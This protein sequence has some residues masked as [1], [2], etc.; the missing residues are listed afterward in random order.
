MPKYK[1]DKGVFKFKHDVGGD[2]IPG[3]DNGF[4]FP[5]VVKKLERPGHD[6]KYIISF[7]LWGLELYSK[8][9]KKEEYKHY[10]KAAYKLAQ[11]CAYQI[12]FILKFTNEIMKMICFT[13]PIKPDS[14]K[15]VFLKLSYWWFQ[16]DTAV[17]SL[18]APDGTSNLL[19]A[20][21]KLKYYGDSSD[22]NYI[23]DKTMLEG[24]FYDSDRLNKVAAWLSPENTN[25]MA[26]DNTSSQTES[27][28]EAQCCNNIN[29]T[30]NPKENLSWFQWYIEQGREA[31]VTVAALTGVAIVGTLYA[32]KKTYDYFWSA[33]TDSSDSESSDNFD[34]SNDSNDSDS[35]P[36]SPSDTDSSSESLPLAELPDFGMP[37]E[38]YY[39][40]D[41]SGSTLPDS[42]SPDDSAATAHSRDH[43]S[44]SPHFFANRTTA[45]TF[46][47]QRT[48]GDYYYAAL[49]VAREG[50]DAR[51]QIAAQSPARKY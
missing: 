48:F 39:S 41:D 19:A 28:H 37:P 38:N 1:T 47:R 24:L 4:E 25:E 27:T 3:K 8:L 44:A 12:E 40:S 23:N 13:N 45:G 10:I 29:N 26:N 9:L 42:D 17:V 15:P 51:A 32:A 21:G 2:T 16:G 6:R 7:T 33:T 34:D 5:L 14:G 35:R 36:S 20:N 46:V 43:S 50:G 11:T 31:P 49:A 18:V 30:Q 22:E